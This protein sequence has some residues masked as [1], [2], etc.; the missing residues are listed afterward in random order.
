MVVTNFGARIEMVVTWS[1]SFGAKLPLH[2]S[3]VD[4][5]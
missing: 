3:T 2:F 5:P 1:R 4:A